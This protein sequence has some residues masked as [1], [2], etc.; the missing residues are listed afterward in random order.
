MSNW[1]QERNEQMNTYPKRPRR[2]TAAIVAAALAGGG[3]GAG[4][5]AATSGGGATKTVAAP[6]AA[7][8]ATAQDTSSSSQLTVSQIYKQSSKSVVE[9][10]VTSVSSNNQP[11]PFGGQGQ[12]EVQGQ[13]TGW[14]Y[15]SKGDIVT[16]QHVVDGATKVRVTFADGST[17]KAKVIG[18]DPSTDIAVIRVDAPSSE[19][20]PLTLGDSSKVAVGDGVV[21]IGDPFGLDNTVTSGI[22]SAVDREITAPDNAPITNAIQTDAAINHGNSGGPLFN[23]QG[24]VIGVTAQIESNSGGNDGIGFAIPSSTVKSI[25]DQLI[26][27]GSVQHALLGVEVQTVPASAA[28]QLGTSAGV[29]VKQVQSGTAASKAGLK[30]STGS[31]TLA[32]VSYPTGNDVITAFNGTKVTTSQQLRALIDAHKPGDTVKLT[33]VHGG[34]TRT[35]EVKLGARSS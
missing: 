24:E 9:V 11:F 12:G 14:V 3:A 23:L 2:V 25:A 5:Y 29:A 31:K 19:L 18:S 34:K 28:S 17:Y 13:G 20:Q 8:T 22:V 32:G 10:D 26:A 21:A 15:D 1:T 4:I 30:G 33:V 6:T 7:A 27:K 35:V 16:N